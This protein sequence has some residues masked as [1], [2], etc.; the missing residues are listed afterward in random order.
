MERNSAVLVLGGHL[1][2][3]WAFVWL[4]Y[5]IGGFV[6]SASER[7][8]W[9]IMGV[10]LVPWVLFLALVGPLPLGVVLAMH[11][12]VVGL[13]IWQW[14][15]GRFRVEGLPLD[16]QAEVR[17]RRHWMRTHRSRLVALFVIYM[18]ANLVWALAF[19]ALT[20]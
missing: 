12:A 2:I 7:R 5:R 10:A 3:L 4:L 15:T 17:K 16:V 19:V 8:K 14:R 18:V 1:L 13:F 6:P 11:A 20:R 9:A